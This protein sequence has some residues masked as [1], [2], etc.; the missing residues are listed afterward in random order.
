MERADKNQEKISALVYKLHYLGYRVSEDRVY[1][2][3]FYLSEYRRSRRWNRAFVLF[4]PDKRDLA[5]EVSFFIDERED[6]PS[7]LVPLEEAVKANGKQN[8][9][10]I[11]EDADITVAVCSD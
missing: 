8:E 5:R 10:L 7:E 3:E 11:N 6:F 4:R 1:N 9:E 2:S